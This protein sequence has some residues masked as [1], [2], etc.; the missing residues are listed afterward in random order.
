MK[1]ILNC[2][3]MSAWALAL[4]VFALPAMARDGT[5]APQITLGLVDF[6][7]GKQ[8]CL[9]TLHGY[10]EKEIIDNY[11]RTKLAEMCSHG[12]FADVFAE[13]GHDVL[14]TATITR[15]GPAITIRDD[16]E[17]GV[18]ALMQSAGAAK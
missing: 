13:M 6:H 1:P 2:I 18:R 10:V 8:M 17:R 12:R 3:V 16:W 14:E 15:D 11:R 7:A 4:S 5:K 9:A